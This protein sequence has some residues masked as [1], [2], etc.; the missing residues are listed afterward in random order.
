MRVEP[1]K[2]AKTEAFTKLKPAEVVAGIGRD[3]ADDKPTSH[4]I[5][6]TQQ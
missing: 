3:L 2:T 4:A 1:V 5:Q 6:V